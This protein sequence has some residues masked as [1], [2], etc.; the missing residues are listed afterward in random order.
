MDKLKLNYFFNFDFLP[1]FIPEQIQERREIIAR[2][3][4][5]NRT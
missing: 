3:I 4:G 5:K 1:V 2:K